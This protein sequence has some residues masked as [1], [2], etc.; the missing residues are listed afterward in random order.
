MA[1]RLKAAAESLAEFPERGRRRADGARE[2]V[3]VH[4]YVVAYDVTPTRVT[5]LRV[6]HGAQSR[7]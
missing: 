5:I 2:L 7:R 1:L 3:A 6:W 4:P